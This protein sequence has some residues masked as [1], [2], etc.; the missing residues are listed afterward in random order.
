MP[1]CLPSARLNALTLDKNIPISV[2]V[3]LTRRCPLSCRHCYLPETAGRARP[4]R[5]LS[6]AQWEQIL[7]QLARAGGLYLVFTGGEPLLR[8]DLAELCRFAKSLSFDVRVFSTGLGLTPARAREFRQ[9]GV[10]AFE[11]S[12][13][14]RPEVHDGL[15]GLKGSFGGSLAAA[16][17]LKAAGVAVKIKVPL[18]N[19]NSG[20]A[21]FLKRLAR[22]EGCGISFDPVIAPANDGDRAALK[23][24]LSGPELRRALS[25]LSP[26]GAEAGP[27]APVPGSAD[28]W[29][30]LCGAGRNVCAVD[31]AGTLFPCLQLPVKLGNLARQKFSA[32]WKGS[33]WL[34]KWRRAGLKDLQDCA[35]C[36]D[37]E[38][39]SRCPGI[40][41][42]EE[43]D[44]FA[45]NRPACE[46]AAAFK[47][48]H[49]RG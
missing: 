25:H 47:K 24:R 27:A 48:K 15:T 44:A 30:F 9:A 35:G 38:F 23:Y 42:L 13:Y 43:G 20:Q 39:C 14:G 6:T 46:M 28:A 2:T 3:E 8:P 32:L 26:S 33:A 11:I 1:D 40:S 45:P 21:A 22:K 16:R 5:E 34:K 29:D 7:R 17:L 36:P 19:L 4:G 31:P 37:I 12:L 49:G 10:S 41:L 18:M